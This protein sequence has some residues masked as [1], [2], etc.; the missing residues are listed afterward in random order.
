M[1]CTTLTVYCLFVT[2]VVSKVV[3]LTEMVELLCCWCTKKNVG[4][5]AGDGKVHCKM[6]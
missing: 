5:L 2:E 6:M 3:S 1:V 4:L